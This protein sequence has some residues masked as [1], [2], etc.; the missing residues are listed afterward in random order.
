MKSLNAFCVCA[1]AVSMAGCAWGQNAVT[2][3]AVI[4]Q[5]AV[6]TPPRQNVYPMVLRA[7]IQIAIYDAV[8]AIA[9]GY[10]PFAA[11]IERS[12][13]ANINAVV[14]TAAWR[15]ARS[16]VDSSR[17]GNLDANY[18]EYMAR[19]PVSTAKSDGIRIGEAAAAAILALR[20]SDG[21]NNLVLYE[22]ISNP[23]PVG[24]FEPDGGCGTQPLAVNAGQ[25]M[26]FTLPDTG[27]FQSDGPTP[28]TSGAYVEDFVETRDY[29][30][31]DSTVR[32]AEQTDI[33]WFW[34]FVSL[35][36]AHVDLAVS[37]GLNVL[38]TARYMAM[39]YT[40]AADANIVGFETKYLYRFWRPR[41]AIPQADADGNADTDADA[42]W[43]PLIS[44]D[45]PEYPSA[46]SFN[47]AAHVDA[48]ARFFG[49]HKVTWT[50]TAN[51]SAAPQ[52]VKTERTY[53]NLNTMMRE[54]NDARIWGGLHWRH[55]MLHGAHIGRKVA[56]HVCDKFFQPE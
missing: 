25:I 9:G 52:L 42:T 56:K 34:Q 27:R 48:M 28:L 18:G 41:T 39:V 36:Q 45:H 32:T 49:T 51:R 47:T 14:A 11:S 53:N 10:K 4:V 5:P 8:V 38:D 22:C 40:A 33:A 13:D 17:V 12:P 55:S 31:V 21:F 30:R 44:V 2:D 46:H 6:N 16:A 50:V 7:T 29:G 37:R 23:A 20:S 24:E 35:H 1:A 43:K 26:P 19:I 54:V 3:W 15:T